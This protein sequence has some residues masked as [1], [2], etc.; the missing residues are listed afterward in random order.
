M[1]IV[2]IIIT[3][4]YVALIVSL[5]IGFTIV[6]EF[7][8]DK[9]LPRTCFSIIVPFRNETENLPSLLKSIALLTY[10]KQLF[11][12][13]LINDYSTDDSVLNIRE[14]QKKHPEISITLTENKTQ[15][16]SPKKD[17]ISLG[18]QLAKHEWIV[19]TDADCIVPKYWLTSFN[20]FIEKH[21]T[22][23]ISAPVTYHNTNSFFK[24]FQLLDFLSLIGATIGCF[25]L[26]LPFLC[27]GANLAY[28]K[29]AFIR[30]NGYSGNTD[31]ASGD[32]IFLLEKMK[33][34]YPHQIHY[35]KN[36]HAI[37]TTKPENTI[38]SLIHQR[39]RWAAK[40]S[41]Y[42]GFFSKLL[43]FIV[44]IMNTAI[45][46]L[47]MLTLSNSQSLMLFLCCFAIKII[48]DIVLLYQISALF[49]QTN[50][51]KSIL[52]SSFI[53]PIFSIYVAFT[54]QILGYTWKSRTFKK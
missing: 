5:S 13:I 32:D 28:K 3:S 8:N 44:L 26:N 42:K 43:G 22:V 33:Q 12:V 9:T 6:P 7:K 1:T 14:F 21:N 19:T 37:V 20:A 11:E 25:G 40:A 39:Q 2:F 52:L 27:N 16:K 18:A 35:L 17:A 31:I 49:K 23:F 15:T 34:Q 41:H 48:A 45:L 4:I 38:T 54:S 47:Y 51:L 53:Y 50:A 10:P 24:R 46:L 36:K 30:V 29:S